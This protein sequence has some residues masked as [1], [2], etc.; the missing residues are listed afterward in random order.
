MRTRRSRSEW[1]AIVEEF[2]HTGQSVARFCAKRGLG[3]AT[4]RWWRT[5]LRDQPGDMQAQS[6]VR[7]LP[8]DLVEPSGGGGAAAGGVIVMVAGVEI[9]VEVGA[10]V[11]YVA[12]L[13]AEL[14]ARC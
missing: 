13:V 2:A 8:V 4:F 1:A 6:L 10:D 12:A 5:Q 9:H 14:R 7:L 11:A 3:V